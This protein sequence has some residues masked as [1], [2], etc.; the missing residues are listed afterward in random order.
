VP[1]D[2]A[3]SYAPPGAALVSATVLGI[4][5]MDDAALDQAVRDQLRGWFGAQVDDWR[6]LR[7][8]RIPFALPAQPPAVLATAERPVRVREGLF[9]CGDHRD[10]ASLQGA[11]V[12][13]R[14]AAAAV[15]GLDTAPT[16]AL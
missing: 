1:S 13:G 8:L 15:R 16:C 4:P 11:M 5:P 3:P 2:V 7:A 14:R 6:L 10:T 9:V 12:S